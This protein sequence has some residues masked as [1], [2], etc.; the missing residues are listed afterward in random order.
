MLAKKGNLHARRKD[1][2]SQ[3]TSHVYGNTAISTD[4]KS[5]VVDVQGPAGIV[6]ENVLKEK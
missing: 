2:D 6:Q 5:K 3:K 4:P 1:T